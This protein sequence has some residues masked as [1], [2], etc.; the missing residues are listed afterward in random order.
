M[1]AAA[2]ALNS[3]ALNSAGLTARQRAALPGGLRDHVITVLKWLLPA[4]ALGVLA[5]IVILPLTKVQEFSFLLAKDKVAVA[6]ERLRVDHAVY[7]GET[8]KGE[9]FIISA[10]GAI[11][12]TSAVPIVELSRMTAELS[13]GT[14]NQATVVAPSGRYNLDTDMLVIA[15]PVAMR[16]ATGYTV[17]APTVT[18]SMADRTVATDDRVS[19]MLPMGTFTANRLRA[20]IKGEVL[21]LDKGAHLHINRRTGRGS[22]R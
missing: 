16:S 8:T 19:G 18:V 13:K 12:R 3:A 9:P 11:Q 17:D 4:A 15:G 22:P 10:E 7:R 6:R 21:V 20:D 5:T 2:P 1:I 14:P